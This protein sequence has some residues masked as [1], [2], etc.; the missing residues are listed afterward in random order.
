MK[1]KD[2]IIMQKIFRKFIDG[3]KENKWLILILFLGIF[4]RIYGIETESFWLD[5]SET[6]FATQK[7]PSYIVSNLYTNILAPEIFGPGRGGGSMPLSYILFYYWTK[8][9]GLNE[10]KLRLLSAIFGVISIYLIYL[11]GKELFNR[12]VGLV[13]A[14]ILAI[15]H[16]HIYYSQEARTYSFLVMSAI[17]SVYFLH[18]M[19]F[20]CKFYHI[21]FYSLATIALLYSHYYSIFLLIFE[22]LYALIILVNYRSNVKKAIISGFII[23]LAYLPWLPVLFRQFFGR[24]VVSGVQGPLT[25]SKAVQNII[26]INSWISPD[27]LTR[28]GLANLEL[29][30]ITFAGLLT[31]LSI[32]FLSIAFILFFLI[33]LF[34][35]FRYYKNKKLIARSDNYLMLLMWFFVPLLIL[36][37]S[38]FI[39]PKTSS[40]GPIRYLLFLTPPYYILISKSIVQF[41][42]MSKL[43]NIS[44]YILIFITLS[45][46]MP[47]YSYYTNYDKG[48]YREAAE[49]LASRAK[50]SDY[51]IVH[52]APIFHS[53]NFYYSKYPKKASVYRSFNVEEL[54]Q[55]T[56]SKSEF[57]AVLSMLKYYDTK[58]EFV[59]YVNQ[60]F[61]VTEK[62]EFIDVNVIKY[63]RADPAKC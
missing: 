35:F 23:L 51:I 37:I 63:R 41:N 40:L 16:Q 32:L 48:Q 44:K 4:L 22:I 19:L 59:N 2:K 57:W 53:F 39:S 5:E 15:N 38:A 50:E 34:S 21:I 25:L 60:N 6:V 62:K 24:S 28:Y 47:L 18:K 36:V 54:K 49:Y 45:S 26:G 52:G 33:G 12:K 14:F 17:F 46:L 61:I 13:A 43:R 20:E 55:F 27:L 11:L 10:F 1:Y 3:I 7:T 42:M 30:S 58:N 8:L 56:D 29:S 31:I 9:V